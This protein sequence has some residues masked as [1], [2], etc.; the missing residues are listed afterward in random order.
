MAAIKP[1]YLGG[2]A[3]RG[4]GTIASLVRHAR[5]FAGSEIVLADIDAERLALVERL[6]QRIIADA[7]VDLRLA[8][9]CPPSPPTGWWRSPA[10]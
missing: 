6:G 2:A 10:W 7:G 3:T 9:L 1:V 4:P 8:V 5:N